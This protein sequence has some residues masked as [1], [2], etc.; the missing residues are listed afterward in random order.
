MFT[1]P[2][3][4]QQLAWLDLVGAS[5][6]IPG[7]DLRMVCVYHVEWITVVTPKADN[8]D[9][10]LITMAAIKWV[11]ANLNIYEK[12]FWIG[13]DKTIVKKQTMRHIF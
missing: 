12:Q 5:P 9:N 6:R 7:F 2:S 4:S 11:C 1:Q 3:F 13:S 8:G 10:L